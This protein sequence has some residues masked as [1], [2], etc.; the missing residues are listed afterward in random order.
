MAGE[1]EALRDDPS[2]QGAL[3]AFAEMY[4]RGM[5]RSGRYA[6]AVTW[7]DRALAL[8]EPIRLDDVIAMALIT[9]GTSLEYLGHPREGIALLNGAYLDA[10]AHGLHIPAL[11][12]GVNLA[13]LTSNTDPRISLQWTRD[14][15]AVA[16]RLGL[17]GFSTYHAGNASAAIRLG[18]WAW[19][20]SA[21][22]E[23]A[24]TVPDAKKR[25]GS[26]AAR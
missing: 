23:L 21:L 8:A 26:A 20:R 4:G 2:A 9:K 22:T 10:T 18:D 15:M 12:A 1:A 17:A 3:A 16:R 14:G 5:F 25:N 11:R 6:E 7:C 24:E 13:A 19:L